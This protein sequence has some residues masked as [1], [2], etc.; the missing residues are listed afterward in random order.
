MPAVDMANALLPYPYFQSF[1]TKHGVSYKIYHF[2][3]INVYNFCLGSC[4][5]LWTSDDMN[6]KQINLHIQHS[7]KYKTTYHFNLQPVLAYVHAFLFI[8]QGNDVLRSLLYT[9][10][11]IIS[12][13]LHVSDSLTVKKMMTIFRMKTS[14]KVLLKLLTTTPQNQRNKQ[15][16]LHTFQCFLLVHTVKLFYSL[17]HTSN[18]PSKNRHTNMFEPLTGDVG[19]L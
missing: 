5:I 14:L 16:N 11:I 1:H 7:W 8:H 2:Y 12:K 17:L 10:C 13:K 4:L 9:W 19:S 3:Q 15:K 6:I 18:L